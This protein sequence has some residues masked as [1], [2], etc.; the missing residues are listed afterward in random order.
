MVMFALFGILMLVGAFAV[1][2]MA[3]GRGEEE[4]RGLGRSLAYL[5][6]LGT[7]PDEL[8]RDADASFKDRVLMPLLTRSSRIARRLTGGEGAARIQ[9][10]LDLAGNPAGW[11]VDKVASAKVVGAVAGFILFALY[12]LLL[13]APLQWLLLAMA[14]GTAAGFFGL[15]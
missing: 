13:S 1:A 10:K 3:I 11:T 2:W 7:A 4:A 8:K 14:G 6:A 15:L 5:E 12:A 9:R